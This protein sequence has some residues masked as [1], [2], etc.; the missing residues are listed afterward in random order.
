VPRISDLVLVSDG[1]VHRAYNKQ[2]VRASLNSL[3]VLLSKMQTIARLERSLSTDMLAGSI[4]SQFCS[5]PSI[6][7]WH[8]H[9]SICLVKRGRPISVSYNSLRPTMHQFP[10]PN[11]YLN[12]QGCTLWLPIRKDLRSQGILP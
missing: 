6:N 8:F 5:I 1:R 11:M 3:T 10:S 9:L 7:G 2:G 4:L 12:A